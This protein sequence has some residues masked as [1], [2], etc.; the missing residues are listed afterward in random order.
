[1]N[2][3]H[4]WT[5]LRHFAAA[6]GV[7]AAAAGGLGAQNQSQVTV[8]VRGG[9]ES[10]DRSASLNKAGVIGIDALYGINKWLSVGP[11][12]SLARPNT[13]GADFVTPI[14]YGVLNL[15]DTT[16]FF[17]AAQPVNIID[18]ALNVRVQLPSKKLS[19]YA[20]GGI[21]G[22]ALFLD[23]QV[24]RGESYRSGVMFNVGAGLLYALSDRAGLTIDVRS[25][26]LTGYSRTALDPRDN[27]NP[28]AHIENTLYAEDFKAAPKNKSAV[29]NF[30]FSFGFSYVPAFFGAGGGGG[31]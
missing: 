14:T 15:G 8:S 20:T 31:Q 3:A 28:L 2:K 17:E 16:S 30:V 7:F 1:M 12:L 27:L 11:V 13:N 24:N 10:Y 4:C 9:V 29:T 23:T 5:S 21:G 6:A 18:G 22:Y 25:T 26:T 19:P